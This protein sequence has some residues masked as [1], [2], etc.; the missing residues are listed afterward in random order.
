MMATAVTLIENET[1]PRGF[2]QRSK[3]MKRR[4]SSSL[5]LPERTCLSRKIDQ[6]PQNRKK[7]S[8]S[9]G[10]NQE[11]D[12]TS[13]QCFTRSFIS[14][15]LLSFPSSSFL[16][17]VLFL[18]SSPLLLLYGAC[19]DLLRQDF[20]SYAPP[21]SSLLFLRD[22][23][24][25]LLSKDEIVS[26]SISSS[27]VVGE[28]ASFPPRESHHHQEEIDADVVPAPSMSASSATTSSIG[29][30]S[31]SPSFSSS[32]ASLSGSSEDGDGSRD[33]VVSLSPLEKKRLSSSSLFTTYSPSIE[34]EMKEDE[35][36]EEETLPSL[37]RM[38]SGDPGDR[39]S[40]SFLEE[41]TS[42]FSQDSYEDAKE[43]EEDSSVGKDDWA[44]DFSE[45]FDSSESTQ[46]APRKEGRTPPGL[47]K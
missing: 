5:F 39:S 11:K 24:S 41:S 42:S 27:P 19:Q 33:V 46:V 21:S 9:S 18:C 15:S 4:L 16:S 36:Q 13:H 31:P 28:L 1:A 2:S 23:P 35:N 44:R 47:A 10:L 45:D 3:S 29:S 37:E 43:E 26:S 8:S 32:F 38:N 7:S 12:K 14:S 40:D 25:S 30:L 17:L 34:D 6:K 22:P 20:S